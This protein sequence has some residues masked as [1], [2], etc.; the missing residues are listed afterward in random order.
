MEELNYE[1]Q[2]G[3]TFSFEEN[4][5]VEEDKDLQINAQEL[6]NAVMDI[7]KEDDIKVMCYYFCKEL[8]SEE[9]E[10]E[11]L[12]KTNLYKRWE[13]LKK[14]LAQ[15]LPYVPTREEFRE[16]AER[17]VSDVCE[18]K[19]YITKKEGRHE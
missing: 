9:I 5:R 18:S 10:L 1:N 15:E 13:R 4:I 14:K 7:L 3:E 8:Y 17:F 11:G 2:E 6:L 12:T 19:G 16:F